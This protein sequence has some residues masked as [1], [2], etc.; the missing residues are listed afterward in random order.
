[1]MLAD[2]ARVDTSSNGTSRF[3]LDGVLGYTTW[4]SSVTGLMQNRFLPAPT[5]P[6]QGKAD[7]SRKNNVARLATPSYSPEDNTSPAATVPTTE[8]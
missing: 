4:G 2:L 6:K 5:K 7:E 1:M 8:G 3:E